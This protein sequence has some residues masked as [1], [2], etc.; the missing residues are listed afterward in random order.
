MD[1]ISGSLLFIADA[2]PSSPLIS[3]APPIMKLMII[4]AGCSCQNTRTE[5]DFEDFDRVGAVSLHAQKNTF[6]EQ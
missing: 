4:Q 3:D 2:G 5:K 1:G 6:C